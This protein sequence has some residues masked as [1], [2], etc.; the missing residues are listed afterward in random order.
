[1]IK[2]AGGS[3]LDQAAPQWPKMADGL[4]ENLRRPLIVLGI[5]RIRA[6]GV[7]HDDE[8]MPRPRPHGRPHDQLR[9]VLV[10]R[11]HF[12]GLAVELR[13]R[14]PEPHACNGQP[15]C[16]GRGRLSWGERLDA[17]ALVHHQRGRGRC[18]TLL[19]ADGNRH[20]QVSAS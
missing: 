1:M 4:D 15:T 18:L 19:A 12:Q 17:R 3:R 13:A 10:R 7:L 11:N 9:S 6:H 5:G 14:P 16:S 2:A 8:L 20:G